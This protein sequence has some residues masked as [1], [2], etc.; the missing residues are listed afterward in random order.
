MGT[1]FLGKGRGNATGT[2][3]GV[4]DDTC[5]GI[6]SGVERTTPSDDVNEV[7]TAVVPVSMA[8]TEVGGNCSPS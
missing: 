8:A 6:A 5:D 7:V 3:E 1:R 2:E 4:I